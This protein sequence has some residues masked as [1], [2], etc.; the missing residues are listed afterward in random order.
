MD[1]F[2]KKD[3]D[4]IIIE[5]KVHP[6]SSKKDWKIIDN[7]L[8]VRIKAQPINGKANEELIELLS[9]IFNVKKKDIIILKGKTSK[10]KLIK[11]LRENL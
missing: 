9:E 3:K 6:R 11:I 10:N 2:Y 4:G 7:G 5:V 8:D 1:L